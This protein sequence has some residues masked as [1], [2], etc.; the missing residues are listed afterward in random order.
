ME[1]QTWE[2]RRERIGKLAY[3]RILSLVK[4][5]EDCMLAD[6]VGK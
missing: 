1:E 4:K 3:G 6:K 2:R 5:K